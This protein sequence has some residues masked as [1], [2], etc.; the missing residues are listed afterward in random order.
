MFFG[1][2]EEERMV[3]KSVR[4]M[5]EKYCQIVDVRAFMNNPTVS[6]EIQSLFGKQGLLG[7]LE[8]NEGKVTGVTY[9]ILISQEA[10]RA[11]LPYPLLENLVGLYALKTCEQHGNLINDVEAGKSMLTIAW[12]NYETMAIRTEKGFSLSGKLLEVPFAADADKIIATV[13]IPGTGY[14]PLEEETVVVLDRS[15]P[16]VSFRKRTGFDETYPIYDVYLD[17]YPLL[18]TD[19]VQGLG[20]GIGHKLM[21]KVEQLGALLSASEMVGSSERALYDTVEYTKQR[22]QFNTVI[23]KFQ[24]LKHMAADMYLQVESA[25]SAI[26]YAAWALEA[27]DAEAESAVSIAKA[28]TSTASKKVIGDA[29]QMQGGI[30]FTWENDLHLF[31][32][33]V[34][35]SAALLGDTYTHNERIAKYV[36]D[37]ISTEKHILEENYQHTI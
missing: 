37:R 20:M 1:F 6:D 23:A 18:E 10:G 25:K 22:K 13:R 28:Y 12:R 24:A 36:L 5:L 4:D 14:T 17:D 26:E 3:Q 15:N 32:K 2:S 11:V 29:I 7:I 8:P 30:G 33:R 19:I 35:R 34:T 21:C 9:A 16:A 27:G 31:F